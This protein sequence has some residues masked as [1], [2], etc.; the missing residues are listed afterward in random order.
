MSVTVDTTELEEQL[1]ELKCL[2]KSAFKGIHKDFSGAFC[3]NLSAVL[4]DVV[5]ADSPTT[6][7]TGLN[8]IHRV[9]LGA[10]YERFTAAIRAG[11]LDLNCL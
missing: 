4:D 11:E 2:I 8:V 10:K 3:R 9:R 6:L 1:T 5:F 7:R